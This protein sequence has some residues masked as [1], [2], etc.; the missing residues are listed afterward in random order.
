M[1]LH[2]AQDSAARQEFG[3]SQRWQFREQ[4]M[5]NIFEVRKGSKRP[6]STPKGRC[7]EENEENEELYKD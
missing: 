6:G 1:N 5:K 2:V 4:E 7:T 3:R